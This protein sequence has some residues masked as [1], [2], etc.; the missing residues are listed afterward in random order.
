MTL[1]LE[2]LGR[3]KEKKEPSVAAHAYHPSYLGG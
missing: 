2:K 1:V 3:E